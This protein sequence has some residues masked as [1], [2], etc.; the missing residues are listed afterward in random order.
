MPLR[1]ST[2]PSEIGR[3]TNGNVLDARRRIEQAVARHRQAGGVGDRGRFDRGLGAVEEA[4]EH[5]RVEAAALGLLGR[6]AVVA[7]HRLGRRFAEVRQP[8]VAAAGG[9]DRKAA[10]ARPVDQVADQRRLVAEGERIDHARLGRLSR[11]Q[12]AAERIGLDRD[13]DDVLAVRERRQAVLDRGD[14]MAGA[15]DDDVD[16]RMR[17]QRLPVLADVGR[18]AVL[19][20]RVEAGR[21]R[22]RVAPADP[23][24][25][26]AC[27]VGRE[28]GDADEMHARRARNLRQVHR[29]ELA[30]ADQAD[31]DRLASRLRVVAVVRAGSCV[32]RSLRRRASAR[33][34]RS[35]AR[36]PACRPST[37]AR[38][39]SPSAGSRRAGS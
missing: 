9:G 3:V 17:H 18:A 23:R 38:P 31:A 10:G 22:L 2:P 27:A 11:Q 1:S 35:R 33:R 34:S 32:G 28:I 25:V 24:Q 8:L 20:R 29:A 37:A 21:A 15:F 4:V 12:R 13:V 7:P 39:G 5:L 30:G 6:Q 36:S 19:Q 16:R 26:S 14:R